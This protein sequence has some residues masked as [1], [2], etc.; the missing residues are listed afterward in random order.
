MPY[1]DCLLSRQTLNRDTNLPLISMPLRS[2]TRR[3]STLM[4][5]VPR[6]WPQPR[7]LYRL[8]FRT[9]LETPCSKRYMARYLRYLTL[10]D[11]AGLAEVQT[12]TLLP[13][14]R[15]HSYQRSRIVLSHPLSYT[16]L[17]LVAAGYHCSHSGI[18]HSS[19]IARNPS[20]L[21]IA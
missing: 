9:F 5:T 8:D 17:D 1:L 18:S 13:F 20:I 21:C 14:Q 4:Y 3:R 19:A 6:A 2:A 12:T 16:G 10:S 7:H 15:H 11:E